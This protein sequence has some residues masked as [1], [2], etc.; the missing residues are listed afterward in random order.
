M[1]VWVPWRNVA[2]A[3]TPGTDSRKIGRQWIE[4]NVPAGA[5]LVIPEKLRMDTR[6]LRGHYNVV[7]VSLRDLDGVIRNA[8]N[9]GYL[10]IPKFG[11]DSRGRTRAA[12]IADDVNKR[13]AA[14]GAR[15]LQQFGTSDVLVNYPEPVPGGDPAFVVAALSEAFTSSPS[16]TT[17]PVAPASPK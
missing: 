17:P 3:Y 8:G 9:S 15:P 7:E 11:Y 16:A 12:E 2:G 5:T 4:K 14:F 10:L 1:L 6:S 13:F